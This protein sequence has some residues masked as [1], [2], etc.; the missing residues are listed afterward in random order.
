MIDFKRLEGKS[1]ISGA[2]AAGIVGF[3]PKGWA[4]GQPKQIVPGFIFIN[5]N[6]LVVKGIMITKI[7]KPEKKNNTTFR[8]CE[9]LWAK[10]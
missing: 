5:N 9:K 2:W 10:M 6:S 7:K 3:R 4:A 1:G 8:V